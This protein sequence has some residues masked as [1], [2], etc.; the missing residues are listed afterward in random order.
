MLLR[1]RGALH[2][3]GLLAFFAWPGNWATSLKTLS[4]ELP[5]WT[6]VVLPFPDVFA[7]FRLRVLAV[8]AGKLVF[9][10]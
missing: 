7:G 3:R 2:F 9:L 10:D 1:R 8:G 5:A 4:L 6:V